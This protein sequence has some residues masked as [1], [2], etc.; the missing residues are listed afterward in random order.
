MPQQVGGVCQAKTVNVFAAAVY[1]GT[2]WP[3]DQYAGI[4]AISALTNIDRE[5][6]VILRGT[7]AA[8]TGYE[9]KVMGPL[10]AT[11]TL[12]IYRFNAGTPTLLT[13]T[14]ATETVSS[15]DIMKC[16]VIG[17]T[18]KLYI[19][20]VEKLSNTDGSPIASG[21]AGIGIFENS[22][23]VQDVQGDNW[24]GGDFSSGVFGR[25]LLGGVGQ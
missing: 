9:C 3:N 7:T 22:G 17:S 8:R 5:L 1:T 15:G 19:N 10:G 20:D 21:S 18:I 14:A 25:M 6:T 16:S 2:A 24:F 11:A 4:T 13:A 23:T 12:R